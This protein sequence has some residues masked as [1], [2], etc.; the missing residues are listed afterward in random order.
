MSG[1]NIE[2]PEPGTIVDHTITRRYLY[3]FYLVSQKVRVGTVS[4]TH[5]IVVKDEA[6][7][8]PDHLQRLSYKLCF[9]YYNWPGP[10]RVPACCQV[11]L[12][13]LCH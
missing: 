1:R 9:L 6:N 11:K 12:K 10:V 13:H 4:P 7:F 2:N 8:Q 5:Y 3:D